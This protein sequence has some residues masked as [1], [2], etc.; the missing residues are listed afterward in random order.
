MFR[1]LSQLCRGTKTLLES[2]KEV[3]PRDTVYLWGRSELRDVTRERLAIG[4][5]LKPEDK[6]LFVNARARPSRAL[7]SILGRSGDFVAF[8]EGGVVAARIRTGRLTPGALTTRRLLKAAQSTERLEAAPD[9]L[10]NGS[11]DLIESNGM[12]IVEQGSRSF[13]SAPIPDVVTFK[14]VP[15]NIRINEAA[16]IDG[17]VSIDARAGPVIVDEGATVESFSVLSGPCYIGQRSRIRSALIRGGTSIFEN[18]RIGGEV[19][20]SIVMSWSNKAHQGYLGDSIVG[21]WVNIGAGSTTSNLKNTYGSIRTDV[22]GRTVDTGMTKFGAVLGDMAKLSI[23]TM[24]Y[25]GKNVGSASHVAGLVDQSVPPFTFFDAR[26]RRMTELDL[27]SVI[28]TQRRMMERRGRALSKKE[29]V[30]LALLFENTAKGRKLA[31]V[32]KGS[33]LEAEPI[34]HREAG[35]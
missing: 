4:Y 32:R 21:E 28:E 33:I 15:S 29:E 23:G 24:V 5:N 1:H 9:L 8:T 26:S 16:E 14:G 27:A 7:K 30:L 22:G 17:L 20:N 18:C 10:F 11:W 2:L 3:V 35:G 19:E 34:R 12:A 6:A 25:A 13:Q 31:G